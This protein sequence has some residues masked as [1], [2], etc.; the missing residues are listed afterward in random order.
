MLGGITSALFGGGGDD[1]SKEAAELFDKLR[2]PSIEEQRLELQ[3]YVEE[4]TL[5]PEQAEAILLESNAYDSMEL[6]TEGNE[7]SL[8][9]LRE[10]EEIGQGE[11]LTASD[12][13]KLQRIASDEQTQSRGAR[14]AIIQNAQ[15]RGAGGSGLEMLN[16]L[17]NAQEAATRQ[18]Q[19][20][21]D[22]AGMAQDRALQA[23]I[24][25]GN[26]GG[27]INQRKFGQ[28][29]A[30]ADSKNAIAKF[31]ADNSQQVGL[32]NTAANNA[33]QEKNLANKQTVSNA[34][35]DLSNQQQ[36]HN[37]GLIQQNFN[38][39]LAKTQGKA[40]ALTAQAQQANANRSADMGLVGS[41]GGSAATLF[42]KSDERAK[43]D[44]ERFDAG[45]FL[46]SLT[47]YKYKYKD[48]SDGAGKQVGVMAQDI[49]KEIPQ[50]VEDTPQGKVV[51]YSPEK[52]SGPIFASLADLNERL[53][54]IEGGR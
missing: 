27:D 29:Q 18:S 47:G 1:Y 16:Q 22:V 36:Q 40:G 41:L 44:I 25:A 46:D 53:R 4:G 11:G 49:E 21:L 10:L 31:N 9:A 8:A 32:V 20:D 6:D 51:D 24:Q 19:R 37:K 42:S 54:R 26:L 43:E 7:A 3:K 34:N 12:R 39:N 30:I 33:A 50:M 45:E 23:I 5:S 17:T 28:Q 48:Q 2:L 13:A 14:E 38:N 35:V 15:A 52:T